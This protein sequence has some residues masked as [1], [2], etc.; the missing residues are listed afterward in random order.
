MVGD[1]DAKTPGTLHRAQ[2]AFSERLYRLFPTDQLHRSRTALRRGREGLRGS[3]SLSWVAHVRVVGGEL[4]AL[5]VL[6]V[7]YHVQQ[8]G[9][10]CA[11]GK[12]SGQ[13]AARTS[14][15]IDRV[16]GRLSGSVGGRAGNRVDQSGG[17][18]E[19]GESGGWSFLAHLPIEVLAASA[20]IR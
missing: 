3:S 20:S 4:A 11:E 18:R 15:A 2:G 7:P 16:P 13:V 14:M 12:V 1:N 19:V 9:H 17:L 10:E 5:S 6:V 8:R